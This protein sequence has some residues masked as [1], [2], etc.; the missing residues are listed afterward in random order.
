MLVN[1]INEAELLLQ[2]WLRMVK[3]GMW[4]LVMVDHSKVMDNDDSSGQVFEKQ[5][6]SIIIIIYCGCFSSHLPSLFFS[7][8][9]AA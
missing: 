4:C 1:V 2:R 3:D 9:Y 7:R 8:R 6:E 5:L